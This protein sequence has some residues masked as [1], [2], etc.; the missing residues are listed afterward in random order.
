MG[1]N[2]THFSIRG[3][4]CVFLAP[5]GFAVLFATP[6][7]AQSPGNSGVVQ[8]DSTWV[9]PLLS[10]KTDETL[11]AIGDPATAVES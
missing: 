6:A 11:L 10:E 4:A 8:P 2:Q 7:D 3:V 5:L 1:V 9:A